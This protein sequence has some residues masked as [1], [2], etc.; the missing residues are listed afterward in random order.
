MNCVNKTCFFS[1]I[2]LIV[3]LFCQLSAY[4]EA[5]V[6]PTRPPSHK[7]SSKSLIGIKAAPKWVL[8]STLIA[9]ARRLAIINGKT[10]SVGQRV[11]TARVLSIEPSQVAIIEGNK[12]IVL[13]LLPDGLKRIR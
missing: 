4:A 2:T 10:V 11:G 6:D 1:V 13:R 5:L 12:E 9:P 8:S 3:T 7:A